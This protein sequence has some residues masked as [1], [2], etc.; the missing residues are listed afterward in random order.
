M[1]L[2]FLVLGELD[3]GERLRT[4]H[5]GEGS[6][7]RRAF[8]VYNWCIIRMELCAGR[9]R[10]RRAGLIHEGETKMTTN[11]RSTKLWGALLVPGI[12]LAGAGLAAPAPPPAGVTTRVTA[13][14]AH[15]KR[16]GAAALT[17][18][19]TDKTLNAPGAVVDLEVFNAKGVRV[20]QKYW[21]GQKLVRGKSSAY[22]WAWKPTTPGAYTIKLGVFGA[23]WK[24]LYHWD[25]SALSLK[26]S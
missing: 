18:A 16:G 8:L 20:A 7:A 6:W 13:A 11:L 9:V 17:V 25:N 15:I 1:F 14:S 19:V 5:A 24:P 12:L 22:R 23:G 4:S 2:A 3:V 21:Q 26:V 10:Q